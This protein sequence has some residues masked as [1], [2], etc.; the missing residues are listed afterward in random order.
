M[1]LQNDFDKKLEQ[2]SERNGKFDKKEI[3]KNIEFENIKK[4]YVCCM[5]NKIPNNG[6]IVWNKDDQEDNIIKQK[7]NYF[8]NDCCI[9]PTKLVLKIKNNLNKNDVIQKLKKLAKNIDIN[10][11]INCDTKTYYNTKH[12]LLNYYL[13]Y[14]LEFIEPNTNNKIIL[15]NLQSNNEYNTIPI[16]LLNATITLNI[17]NK[18]YTNI[19]I[20]E[21][22]LFSE[23]Y[24]FPKQSN[25]I[26]KYYSSELIKQNIIFEDQS[27]NENFNVIRYNYYPNYT[28]GYIRY[29]TN[30]FLDE[31]IIQSNDFDK[32]NKIDLY[33]VTYN[34]AIIKSNIYDIYSENKFIIKL[35]ENCIKFNLRHKSDRNNK[36]EKIFID[37]IT[38]LQYDELDIQIYQFQKTNHNIENNN[39]YLNF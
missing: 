29:L 14:L 1:F 10:I 23:L 20:D 2:F 26:I 19:I 9:R 22:Y 32:I 25:Y 17:I 35:S 16:T 28:F 12:Q 4:K 8:E 13:Y 38:K 37:I 3:K 7:V 18:I 21:F 30:N 33:L 24:T 6:L 34:N 5:L 11:Q 31:L 36:F 27:S 15:L 39:I